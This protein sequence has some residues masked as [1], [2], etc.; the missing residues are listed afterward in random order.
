MSHSLIFQIRESIK[1]LET[2][3][4]N[5]VKDME[6]RR[7]EADRIISKAEDEKRNMDEGETA[8]FDELRESL[9]E[10]QERRNEIKEE[11][12]EFRQRKAGLDQYAKIAEATAESQR[13]WS[14]ER[15]EPEPAEQR[16]GNLRVKS[17]PRTYSHDA[18]RQGVSF[19]EDLYR[20][21]RL[22][23]SK[24]TERLDRHNREARLNEAAIYEK[25][26]GTTA[27]YSGLTVP[28]YLTDM[29][30]PRVR[31]MAPTVEIC[32]RHP[33]PADGM[34][35]NISR[36]T[37]GSTVG[38]QSGEGD[39]VDEQDIDDTLLTV[40][41]RTYAGQQD[42]S[43]Q[44]LERGSGVDTIVTQDLLAAYWTSLDSA[45]INGTGAHYTHL[46]IRSTSNV[47][48]V[49]YADL[50]PTAAELHPKLAELISV[51]QSGVYMGLSH[52]IMHPRRWWWI[53]SQLPTGSPI[54]TVPG[55]GTQQAG[56]L[57]STA[58]GDMGRNYL[59]V[60]V[61]VDGNIPTTL[62]TT[63]EDVILGVTADEL[64]LWHDDGPL[65]I[66]ADQ[67]GAADLEIKYV[68]Y[69]Y[70]AF[71]CGRLP[72]AHAV[73]SSTGLTVPSF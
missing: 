46:G 69:S 18:E 17:E 4:E 38:A 21:W 7:V 65:F 34:T 20:S 26:D 35:V 66:R 23:D 3:D 41:V 55:A 32:N 58:Y 64:H 70:S 56:Q 44:A 53:A 68:V 48:S 6:V 14:Q 59:G 10:S 33:L 47:G 49:A 50:S 9:A 15:G 54:V 42:L 28:Q 63:N 2:E 62:G 5:I 19:Y 61:V 12:A 45:I 31:A 52:F 27:N 37:T 11:L 72:G 40:N 71:S 67:P 36:I 51:V 43:R 13:S 30:M 73:L 24:A 16:S 25:R 1:A 8:R 22:H 57:G 29:V 60:P 39:T